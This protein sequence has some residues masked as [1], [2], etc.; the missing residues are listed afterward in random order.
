M[1]DFQTELNRLR[2][3]DKTADATMAEYRARVAPAIADRSGAG[4]GPESSAPLS[5]GRT[6][7]PS[8]LPSIVVARCS[9]GCHYTAEQWRQLPFGGIQR[10]DGIGPD[11]ELRHCVCSSTLSVPVR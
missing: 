10:M 5:T 3:Q 4:Q 1:A 11:L 9:C 6:T 7:G 2:A 8:A